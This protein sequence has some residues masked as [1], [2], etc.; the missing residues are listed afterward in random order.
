M[1]QGSMVIPES[2]CA[3]N[4][5]IA[6]NFL[7]ILPEVMSTL[8]GIGSVAIIAYSFFLYGFRLLFHFNAKILMILL[9]LFILIF[10][11]D[12]IFVCTRQ[13]YIA[14]TY[15]ND[16]DLVFDTASCSIFRRIALTCFVGVTTTQL[17]Q[18]FER[19]VAT[20][21]KEKYEFQTQYLG[22]LF[23]LFSVL[24]AILL[25][26]WTLWNENPLEPMTHC[27]AYSTSVSISERM[28]IVFFGILAVDI[29][30]LAVFC[31]MYHNNQRKV[32]SAG[33]NK[34]YQQ[35]ENVVVLRALF[36]MVFL[37]TVFVSTYIM[38]AV[39]VRGFRDLMTITNYKLFAINTFIFPYVS[40]LLSITILITTRNEFRRRQQRKQNPNG[41]FT[42]QTYFNQYQRQWSVISERK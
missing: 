5:S 38:T 26:E 31:L 16:C 27:L 1:S 36:P 10:S 11:L 42:T 34:K 9:T 4:R 15:E 17:A 19:L 6:T 41:K 40:L 21:S 8:S 12:V 24:S 37:N 30:I 13:V 32:L 28:Y 33:L 39:I 14:M 3:F 25:I 7:Y 23:V 35:H 18:M 22:G 20:I 29:F 2:V